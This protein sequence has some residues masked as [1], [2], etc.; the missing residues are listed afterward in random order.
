M[1]L[2]FVYNALEEWDRRHKIIIVVYTVCAADTTIY[3]FS[4]RTAVV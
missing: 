3:T 2:H 1:L 4:A